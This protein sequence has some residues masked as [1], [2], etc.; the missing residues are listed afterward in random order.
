MGFFQISIRKGF[1]LFHL[2]KHL[3]S[4]NGRWPSSSTSKIKVACSTMAGRAT[5]TEVFERAQV[6][7][8]YALEIRV[9]SCKVFQFLFRDVSDIFHLFSGIIFPHP[10]CLGFH[11]W[12]SPLFQKSLYSKRIASVGMP[13]KTQIF[14]TVRSP[15][16]SY[17]LLQSGQLLS[18]PFHVA[19]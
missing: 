19:A 1:I 17:N 7:V 13:P 9:R 6:L 10:K 8:G 4:F 16:I 18:Y 11:S 12:Q 2:K 3:S 15:W 5:S 14:K